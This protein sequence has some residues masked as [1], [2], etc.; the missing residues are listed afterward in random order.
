[1]RIS[2]LKGFLSDQGVNLVQFIINVFVGIK[3]K[4]TEIVLAV[5]I[6]AEVLGNPP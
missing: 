5:T 4:F 1:M 3:Y 2:V 6:D